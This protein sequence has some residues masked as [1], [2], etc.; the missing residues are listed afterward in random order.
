[1]SLLAFR[2]PLVTALSGA[3]A[4]ATD[5][6]PTL[7][8]G[9]RRLARGLGALRP[10]VI[11]AHSR[12]RRRAGYELVCSD[13]SLPLPARSLS[14]LVALELGECSDWHE[15]LGEWARVVIPG[16]AVVSVDAGTSR[17]RAAE[18]TRRILCAGLTGIEQ[19]QVGRKLVTRGLVSAA[20]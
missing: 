3:L 12:S 15:R 18:L 13:T 6:L 4:A 1:M 17:A 14:G 2:Q 16:G 20:Y 11:A 10:N 9:D 19:R 5:P 7:V 8:L